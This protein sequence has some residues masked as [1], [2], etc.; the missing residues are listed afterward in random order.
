MRTHVPL[1]LASIVLFSQARAARE[2]PASA[3]SLVAGRGRAAPTSD[4][5][6]P[7]TL[8]NLEVL[9]G[10]LFSVLS[11]LFLVSNQE[12]VHI[13]YV[14]PLSHKQGVR[15]AAVGS[16]GARSIHAGN[17]RARKDR[18]IVHELS[19]PDSYSGSPTSYSGA[20]NTEELPT[21]REL[22]LIAIRGSKIPRSYGN[23]YTSPN[24]Y[25]APNSYSGVIFF[26]RGAIRGC[27]PEE[28]L[29]PRGAITKP[30]PGSYLLQDG[31]RNAMTP[32]ISHGSGKPCY[33]CGT[34][35][36]TASPPS[37]RRISPHCMAPCTS[38]ARGPDHLPATMK[39]LWP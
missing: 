27:R 2:A 25:P 20:E 4:G 15:P 29:A 21:P 8:R 6:T 18:E 30:Q 23:L 10:V 11:V 13:V 26:P 34:E 36:C 16:V 1:R 9:V 35:S 28:L 14:P 33:P 19:A 5:A 39:R 38:N 17:E 7:A 37:G 12:I 32:D 31:P 24:S 22:S 3:P